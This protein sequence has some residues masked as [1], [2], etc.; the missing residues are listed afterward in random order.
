MK[1]GFDFDKFASSVSFSE[2][3]SLMVESRRLP[4]MR[5]PDG[6]WLYLSSLDEKV[7]KEDATTMRIF[8]EQIEERLPDL[9]SAHNPNYSKINDFDH[10]RA[11]LEARLSY[12]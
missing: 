3:R 12:L 1:N 2:L 7:G 5:S 10:D 6:A 11:E 4:S 9:K 8:L